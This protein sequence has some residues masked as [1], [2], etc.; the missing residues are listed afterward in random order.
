MTIATPPAP[1]ATEDSPPP[2]RAAESSA[3]GMALVV[4]V[5]LM[6]VV[7]AFGVY[8]VLAF[9]A[10]DQSL[11][12]IGAA[13]ALALI[14]VAY[15]RRGLL[16]AKYIIPGLLFLVVF[17]VLVIGYTIYVSTTNYGF[18][19]N[20]TQP[21]AVEAILKSSVERVEGSP[22][23]PV[24]VLTRDGELYLLATDPDGAAQLGSADTPLAPAPD[25]EF[26]N[27]KAKSVPGYTTLALADLLQVQEAVTTL[28]VPL[29][30]SAADGYLKTADGRNAY[31]YK[32]T[33]VY[34]PQAG[35][36]TD[37]VTGV[38]YTDNGEG[39]FESEDG[40]VLQPGWK[41]FVG[42]D[43]YAKALGS[44]GQAEIIGVFAWTFVFAFFSVL[45]SFAVGTFLALVFNDPR[46]RFRRVYRVLMI[47]PYAFPLF[48]SGLVWSGLLNQQ[49]GFINQVL[50][51]GATVPW[52][53]DPMLAR[54]TVIAVSVW[55]GAPYF[56]LVCTGALQAI[57]E[58]VQQAARVDGASPWQLFRLIKLPLLLIS[59]SPLLIAAFAFSFNDFSTIFM[60]SGG[61]PGDPT[62][63]IGAGATDILI[64]VVYKLAFLPGQKDYGLASAFAV[65]IFAIVSIISL[66]LF[67]RTKSLE[68][69]Y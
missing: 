50:L 24:A 63:P 31:V 12:G 53:Q 48:L 7:D 11:V 3:T 6:A 65:I 16:A 42:L 29:G 23:Y 60:L 25:A 68:E 54:A 14:N 45:L 10:S 61:G 55:F 15:F 52:L 64:T 19:H 20:V 69:I 35:T 28:E 2:K 9:F 37:S 13:I 59:V 34:D 30:E 43:N 33:L 58:D 5:A 56:F 44:T 8:L 1:P 38:V 62:S 39:N 17:Q 4:K 66:V 27:G 47:L 36:M 40:E 21:E 57:P 32:S 51:G 41:A 18:G 26:D 49:Y 22:T 67:R 46:L